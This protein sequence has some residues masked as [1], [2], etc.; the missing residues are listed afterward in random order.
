MKPALTIIIP[1]F[2][3]S[4][5]L[6]AGSGCN[7]VKRVINNPNK[8]EQVAQ[9][10]VRRG[11]CVNDTTRTDTVENIIVLPAKDSLV[12]DTVLVPVFD[13][14][15]LPFDTLLASGARLSVLPSGQ[16]ELACPVKTIEKIKTITKDHY[17][18]DRRLETLL[19][20][21][22]DQRDSILRI[23]KN[24]VLLLENNITE[25]EA[26]IKQLNKKI[27]GWKIKLYGLLILVILVIGYKIYRSFKII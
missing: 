5:L 12:R 7:P 14:H 9:E 8:F 22:I 18:R 1:G 27:T 15:S 2:S 19:Q 11:Y 21:D 24:K 4:F 16:I 3:L 13:H 10:V 23:H 17:I 20:Q 6:I 25:N 26:A